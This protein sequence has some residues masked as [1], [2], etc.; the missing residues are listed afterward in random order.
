VTPIRLTLLVLT[1]AYSLLLVPGNALAQR[2]KAHRQQRGAKQSGSTRTVSADAFGLKAV[3]YARRFLGVPY[4]WG[5]SSPSGFDC[6]GLVRFVYGHFGIALPHS[7]YGD[8]DLGRRISRGA[9][10]PGDLVFFDGI[11]HVGMYI[12]RGRFIHA[13]HTGTRVQI[14]TL[15]SYGSSYDG[16]RRIVTH[17]QRLLLSR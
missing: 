10:R 15:A 8:F 3:S 11:G 7:S 2:A 6:S 5:G 17:A 16:A 12:G 9:L 13:P 4:R 1:L 14:T